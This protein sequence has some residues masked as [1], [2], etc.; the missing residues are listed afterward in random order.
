MNKAVLLPCAVLLG[1]IGSPAQAAEI[2]YSGGHESGQLQFHGAVEGSRFSGG[3]G[4]F[5]VRYCMPEALPEQGSIEVEVQLASAD[6]NNRDRDE[7]LQDEEFFDVDNHPVSIWRSTSIAADDDGYS[8]AGELSLKG[9]TAG[10]AIRFTLDPN[11]ER[12]T[13]T[14]GFKLAGDAEVDRQRF[15]IG[16]GEFADPEFVRNRVDVTFE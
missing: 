13:V 6:S 1:W 16:T 12:I 4:E 11:G 5:R 3:F 2:C 14:G 10:Q 9:I 7:A 15:E 8:A